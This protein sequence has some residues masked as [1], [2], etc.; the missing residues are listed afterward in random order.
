MN[1]IYAIMMI[2]DN[3]IITYLS[4]A[5]HDVIS[6]SISLHYNLLFDTVLN[7]DDY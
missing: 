1:T 6:T 5:I 4:A 3:N 2:T 7:I